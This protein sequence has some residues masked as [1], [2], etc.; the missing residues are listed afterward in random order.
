MKVFVRRTQRHKTRLRAPS[1]RYGVALREAVR[2]AAGAVTN[3]G[4]WYG[5]GFSRNGMKEAALRPG[6][7]SGLLP[8]LLDA[9]GAQA[10]EAVLVDGELPGQEFVD[11]QRVAA[12]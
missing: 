1:T 7:G 12:A 9:G 5:P 11:G 8:V 10:G 2:C 4:A 6:Q 3:V